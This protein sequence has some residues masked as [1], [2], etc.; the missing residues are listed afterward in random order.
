MLR[1]RGPCRHNVQTHAMKTT[2]PGSTR[3]L[4]KVNRHPVAFTLS[5]GFDNLDLR[6]AREQPTSAAKRS[7]Q[8]E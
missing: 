7:Q 8:A 2:T 1:V 5:S 6:G 3:A 4:L